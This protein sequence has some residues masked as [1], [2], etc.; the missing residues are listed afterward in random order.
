MSTP[1]FNLDFKS[2]IGD[3]EVDQARALR[4]VLAVVQDDLVQLVA[5]AE[6]VYRDKRGHELATWELVMGLAGALAHEWVSHTDKET[7]A[8]GIQ[9]VLLGN[10]A[11]GGSNV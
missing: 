7:T 3:K 10:A 11:E 1:T 9:N 6:D 5:V 8:Q 2:I 4:M